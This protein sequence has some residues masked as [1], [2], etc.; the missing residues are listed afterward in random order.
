MCSSKYFVDSNLFFCEFFT[1]FAQTILMFLHAKIAY[2]FAYVLI[3]IP[4][5]DWKIVH[6]LFFALYKLGFLMP[7]KHISCLEMFLQII[8]SLVMSL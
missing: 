8:I 3:N 6:C 5:F 1:N 4:R 7:Q 2:I